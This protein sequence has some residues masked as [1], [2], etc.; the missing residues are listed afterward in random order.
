MKILIIILLSIFVGMSCN[1]NDTAG[2]S[3]TTGPEVSDHQ[4]YYVAKEGKDAN[5]GSLDEPVKTI[6]RG[7]ELVRPGDTL[8]V[9][10]GTYHEKISFRQSGNTDSYI[11]LK[12]YPG[13]KVVLSGE[14]LPVNGNE[15]LITLNAVSWILIEGFDICNFKTYNAQANVDGIV[16]KGASNHIKI[17]KNRVFHIENNATPEQG[18]SGHGIHIIGDKEIPITAILVEENEIFD[19]NTGYSENL[20]VNGF[21]DGF[22]IRNNKVYNGENIGIVAAGGY[23]ANSNPEYNY[24]R[25]GVIAGNEVFDI[26]GRSG[27][28]PAYKEHNG[29]IG[30][31]VDG[32]R[33]IIVERN[34]VYNNGRG[35]GIVSEND[36]FPTIDCI[37]R[38]NFIYNCSM[39]G[40]YLG[41]YIGYTGG[42][43][44]RCYVINNTLY[45][46]NKESG[47]FGE[48]EGEIRLT[49]NCFDN[50]ILNNIIYAR[51]DKNVFI[52]KY[53]TTGSNNVIDYNLYYVSGISK[54]IWDGIAYTD[55]SLWKKACHG[56]ASST[57]G[58]DPLLVNTAIPDLHIRFSSPGHNSGLVVS[59]NIHGASDIDGDDRVTDNKVSK[60]A[61]APK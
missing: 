50:T 1:K 29:A 34:I 59:A 42:G 19:C 46:N 44:K 28:I 15:S 55:F 33:N 41:G 24:A 57:N 18:R 40:I 54:W 61:D 31:Y 45:H 49:E 7:L 2:H 35:I 4:S 22:E 9:R 30:I 5:N 52:H 13:E 8:F 43:T 38:N 36:N 27:P 10:E 48:V 16:V 6:K 17:R 51:S 37:V 60:G 58:M 23:A 32:A 47:Y 39:S 12:I 53:T 3:E 20:T 11:S 25:N 21:V 56:D 26:D 14:G